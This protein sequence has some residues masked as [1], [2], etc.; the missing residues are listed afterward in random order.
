MSSKDK[1]TDEELEAALVRHA[2][3]AHLM[4]ALM[5]AF[6]VSGFPP[7]FDDDERQRG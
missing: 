5:L 1:K 7:L 4:D 6:C 3:D 2:N